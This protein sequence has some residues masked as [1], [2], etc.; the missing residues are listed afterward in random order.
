MIALAALLA[1]GAIAKS[2]LGRVVG[3]TDGDTVTLLI[4][5]RIQQRIRLAGIDAPEKAQPFGS[6]AKQQL[7]SLV[8][9][10]TVT[11]VGER[12]DRYHRLI[13]K[14]LVDGQDVNLEMVASGYAWHF[15]RYEAEQSPID[16][17]I[18]GRREREARSGRRGLWAD[19]SPVAPWDYR[20]RSRK[21][22]GVRII[23]KKLDT[24]Q[25]ACVQPSVGGRAAAAQETWVLAPI[26]N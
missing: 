23:A 11:V 10:K 8:F 7:S 5:G 21:A 16:R 25:R 6:R 26:E 14:I 4:N 24:H 19:A 12:Q 13:G 17:V 20:S 3:V 1:D 9:G 18:Y 22:V 15:K 2:Q